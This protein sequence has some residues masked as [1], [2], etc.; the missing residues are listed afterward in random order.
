MVCRGCDNC[1]DNPPLRHDESDLILTPAIE[2]RIV[3]QIEKIRLEMK[4]FPNADFSD[5]DYVE[6]ELLKIW[7]Q[8]EEL[9]ENRHKAN[10]TILIKRL[11]EQNG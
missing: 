10:L 1:N 7:I 4:T 5:L 11:I 8:Q 9:Y 2:G 3:A 6:S